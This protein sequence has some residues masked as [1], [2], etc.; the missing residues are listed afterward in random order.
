M[1]E[2]PLQEK[3]LEAPVTV[4]KG[5]GARRA[6][7]LARLDVV[8]LRDLLLHVPVRYEERGRPRDIASLADG[9]TALVVAS[10]AAPPAHSRPRK[11]LSL[12]RV[13]VADGTGYMTAVFFNR[14]FAIRNLR[15]GDRH[16][17]YG[18]VKRQGARVEMSNP[19]M[20]KAPP[21]DAG[22]G[23]GAVGGAVGGAVAGA[24]LLPIYRLT[25]G[26]SQLQLRAYVR[27][28]L[29]SLPPGE[30]E[31]L[32][33][34]MRD[35]H[36][37]MAWADAVRTVHTPASGQEAAAARARLA[38]DELLEIQVALRVQRDA[39]ARKIGAPIHRHPLDP[40]LGRLPYRC[41]EAQER[42]IADILSDMAKPVAMNRLLQGDVGSGKTLVALVAAYAAM[43]D[44]WQAALM[45]PT[46][47]LA[48]Q[49]A[50]AAVELLGPLGFQVSLL[51]G[52]MRKRGRDAILSDLAAGRIHLVIGTHAL[53]VG[54][55]RFARLGLVITDE[56]HRFGVRQRAQLFGKGHVPHM[57]VMTATPIPRTLTLAFY[58]DLDV[59]VIDQLPP[60]RKP[61]R[62]YVVEEDMRPRIEA[63]LRKT[64]AQGQ[65]A[66][67]VC[68]LVEDSEEMSAESAESVAARYRDQVFPDLRVG[69]L[70]GRMKADEKDRV[71]QAFAAGSLD[72]L[73]STTVIEVG[74][75]VPNAC[76]MVVENAERFGLS[77]LHQLRGRV[78][79]GGAQS[80]CV[81]FAGT[82][83]KTSRDRLRA[84][85]DTQDGFALAELDLK[86]R[87][88]GEV[89][90]TRQSGLP[91]CR[92][93]DPFVDLDLVRMARE[94]AARL[95]GPEA[96]PALH[97]LRQ[98]LLARF[99]RRVRD[100][101]PN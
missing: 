74:V 8:T 63:F 59:S 15:T 75:N 42:V 67:V 11:G 52:G 69:M 16:V 64:V 30:G 94:E 14:D 44:G 13:T 20:E 51:V 99:A 6:E 26:V 27:E 86:L 39:G 89:L 33:Q 34:A 24:G 79:R 48:R 96:D 65:Q 93:A 1:A 35:R 100:I 85:A 68:P 84:I 78:G 25:E 46:E 73:V 29:R 88:P 22:N 56:Q 61:I 7:Q 60:G 49:H 54:D 41:T 83:T 2:Q 38:F 47:I 101:A 19:V 72:I 31:L 90:G 71:M 17:F 4:I 18:S 28:A 53:L 62:T 55:V 92:V 82:K 91:E 45:A 58:G 40:L 9:E 87:G 5:I 3:G 76:V 70:H 77:Q 66:Y 37:L 97:P 95:E 10:V 81:L 98:Q 43:A 12:W 21:E 32:P 23:D 50:Q 36:G 57:L 80:H